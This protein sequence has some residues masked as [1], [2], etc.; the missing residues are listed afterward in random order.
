M[1]KN[2]RW[3]YS[4]LVKPPHCN[5]HTEQT[6]ETYGKLINVI[7]PNYFVLSLKTGFLGAIIYFM[8]V[9]MLS[10]DPQEEYALHLST[11]RGWLPLI[12]FVVIVG[13]T[14][15]HLWLMTRRVKLYEYGM[16]LCGIRGRS[17]SYDAV[18]SI[19]QSYEMERRRYVSTQGGYARHYYKKLII[20]VIAVNKEP[21][22]ILRKRH[23]FFL[24]SKLNDLKINLVKD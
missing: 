24:K 16:K 14:V 5:V 22:L 11:P 9:K 15:Y 18:S 20:Y 1:I 7:S 12:P 10:G 17:I 13:Y 4:S 19:E 3:V 23:Y 2:G 8:L 21:Q 6:D